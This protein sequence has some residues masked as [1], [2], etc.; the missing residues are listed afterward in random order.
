M[1]AGKLRL[2]IPHLEPHSKFTESID[3]VCFNPEVDADSAHFTNM[4]ELPCT[5]R[6]SAG[7]GIQEGPAV[8]QHPTPRAAGPCPLQ[9]PPGAQRLVHPTFCT[10]G[11]SHAVNGTCPQTVLQMELGW[12]LGILRLGSVR[13]KNR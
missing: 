7:S 6:L 2:V 10:G 9:C 4:E 13:K 8:P 3:I 1:Q 11:S 5:A 12:V